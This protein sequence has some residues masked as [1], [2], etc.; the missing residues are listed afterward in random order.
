MDGYRYTLPTP[1]RAAPL[2][3][4]RLREAARLIAIQLN[5][6]PV[7]LTTGV[8]SFRRALQTEITQSLPE[9]GYP[10]N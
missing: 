10:R 1:R 5:K 8:F 3:M 7:N 6:K 4:A 2:L 9:E